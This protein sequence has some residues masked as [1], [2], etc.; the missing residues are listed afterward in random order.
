MN[1]HVVG[2]LFRS[3]VR[4]TRRDMKLLNLDDGIAT[5]PHLASDGLM[6]RSYYGGGTGAVRL[7]GRCRGRGRGSSRGG[8][9]G[10][11]APSA[12][13]FAAPSAAGGPP[14]AVVVDP[15]LLSGVE[16]LAFVLVV[17][18]VRGRRCRPAREL[19]E[20]VH[21]RP[22]RLTT[23]HVGVRRDGVLLR[24]TL[25]SPEVEP[26]VSL[27]MMVVV[28]KVVAKVGERVSGVERLVG[29]VAPRHRKMGR[30]G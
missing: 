5:L 10:L 14:G 21:H 24:L 13:L 27:M 19:R 17:A 30:M 23:S 7:A 1:L 8:E 26:R 18:E 11:V 15:V 28:V 22:L 12:F 25:V 16:E 29:G 2:T 6:Y 3:H 4:R 20:V 9:G